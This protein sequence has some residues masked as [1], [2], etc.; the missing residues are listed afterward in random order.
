MLRGAHRGRSALPGNV[1]HGIV[2][3]Q[4]K[5]WRVQGRHSRSGPG[6]GALAPAAPYSHVQW[7]T[8]VA[9]L[10]W[11]QAGGK[12][13]PSARHAQRGRTA[14]NHP[15]SSL[16]GSPLRVQLL[17]TEVRGGSQEAAARLALSIVERCGRQQAAN[18]QQRGHRGAVHAVRQAAYD[19]RGG[20]QRGKT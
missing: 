11:G 15:S 9:E 16:H 20:G 4:E 2:C 14:S 12:C 17:A 8:A 7:D 19:G 6:G 1:W 10:G 3:E 5:A 13:H 18:G